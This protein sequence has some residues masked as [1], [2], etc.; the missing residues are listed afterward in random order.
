MHDDSL[1]EHKDT[2]ILY[3][4]AIIDTKANAFMHQIC[5]LYPEGQKDEFHY[6]LLYQDFC[7]MSEGSCTVL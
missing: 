7:L 2:K 3:D 6:S 5:L 1:S 4:D